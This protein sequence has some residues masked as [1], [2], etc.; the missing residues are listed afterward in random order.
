MILQSAMFCL[1]ECDIIIMLHGTSKHLKCICCFKDVISFLIDASFMFIVYEKWIIHMIT[2]DSYTCKYIERIF[3]YE[4]GR[5][6]CL[7]NLGSL[8]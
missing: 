2:L 7:R 6:W 8:I 1:T 3:E 4:H 5:Y